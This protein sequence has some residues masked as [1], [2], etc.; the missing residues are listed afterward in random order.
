[1]QIL[2]ELLPMR[3]LYLSVPRQKASKP[4][5][6]N[7]LHETLRPKLEYQLCLAQLAW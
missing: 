7:T 4:S 3:V 6:S 5:A 2:P 1:M